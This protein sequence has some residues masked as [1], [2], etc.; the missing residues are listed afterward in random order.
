MI[1]PLPKLGVQALLPFPRADIGRATVGFRVSL[2]LR[3]A[4]VPLL[5][6]R[7]A[8]GLSGA[9]GAL[10]LARATA[11][12]ASGIVRLRLLRRFLAPGDGPLEADF[13]ESLDALFGQGGLL[14][15]GPELAPEK[16][17]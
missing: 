10:V 7:P 17:T 8:L 12:P 13:L 14:S 3:K 5:L 15:L 1:A 4:V 2:E 9:V 6:L 11:G 16:F